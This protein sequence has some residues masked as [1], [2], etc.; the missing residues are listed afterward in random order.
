MELSEDGKTLLSVCNSDIKQDGTYDIPPGVTSIR[1]FAFNDCTKLQSIT[2]PQGVTSIGIY[3]FK[4]CNALQSITIPESVTSI[5][6][7][8]F[9]GCS[10]LQSVSL[11]ESITFIGREVFSNCSRLQLI[12][13]PQGVTA[14]DDYAFNGC[15]ELQSIILPESITSIFQ[16]VFRNC[17]RLHSIRIAS[18]SDASIKRITNL[19]P[20]DLRNKV[21]PV[22]FAEKVFQILNDQL[23]QIV[24]TPQINPLYCFFNSN[25]RYVSK[26]EVENGDNNKIEIECSKLPNG[27]FQHMNPFIVSNNSFYHE[28]KTRM[29]G[30]PLPKNEGQIKT[31]K[32]SLKKIANE[33]IQKTVA[34]N[35]PIKHEDK[36]EHGFKP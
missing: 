14:I 18:K 24:Q 32:D 12:T 11:P 33:F 31:Y 26:V 9:F 23:F 16:E 36:T 17:N 34:F 1:H 5:G 4:N 30:V 3:A 22:E 10:N 2:I 19:L 27:I 7:C 25:T 6:R 29:L 15:T 13:I 8:T 20:N 35:D 28:A 21:I